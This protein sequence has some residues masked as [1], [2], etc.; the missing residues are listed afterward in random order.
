MNDQ[1]VKHKI[2]AFLKEHTLCVISTI[3]ADGHGPES[4]VVA[5]VETDNLE[6]VFGTSNI[7]RKYKNIQA[8]NRVAL[9]I[10]WSSET[11][12]I[13]YEGQASELSKEESEKYALLQ[14]AKNPS[15]ASF[16]DREDQRYF[17]VKPSW[18]R[19]MDFGSKPPQTY[20]LNF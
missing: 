12:T 15:S 6:I 19:F 13:Q 3:H 2:L 8:D 5:F 17:I 20:E 18:I 4:A 14:I 11:G 7:S 10:G 1:A 9:V 16:K